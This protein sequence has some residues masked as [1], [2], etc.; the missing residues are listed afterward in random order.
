MKMR[1]KWFVNLKTR[2]KH[3]I[4]FLLIA[5]ISAVIGGL[6]VWGLAQSGGS[7]ILMII[8]GA[9]VVINIVA[10]I[11]LA[12]YTA[13]LVVDPMCK[14]GRILE[15]YCVGNL[16]LD[17]ILR[18]RDH[19]TLLYQ[20]EIG[21]VSRHLSKLMQYML[22]IRICIEELAK[23]DLSV[24]AP[25]TSPEDQIGNRLND[26]VNNFHR[27]V[28]AIVNV[29]N[30]VASNANLVSDSSMA[31]SQGAMHQA[32]AV[33][34]LTSSLEQIAAQTNLNAQNAEKAND[35]SQRT[36]TNAAEG[37]AQMKDMLTAMDDISVSSGS[38]G[39][40]IKVI[41]DIAFQ[42]NILALNAAVEAARAGQ[43]GKGFAV[44]AEEV[45][46]LAGKS[47]NAAR[48]T[49]EL[50]ENSIRKVETGAR[51]AN[52]T[53]K[54]LGEIVS[55]VDIAADL[56][57]SIAMAS[58]EQ[59]RGLDQVNAGITQ[60]SQVIQTNVATAQESAAASE[61]LSS[62]AARLQEQVAVF[63]LRARKVDA[64]RELAARLP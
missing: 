8:I 6:G 64:N 32:S 46:N 31:L 20:D 47:A 38:I 3:L 25:V 7:Q 28:A 30:Q 9:V 60:V 16:S 56:I 54:A 40:I 63:R 37:N 23:G 42:T 36:K 52:L 53:A 50:I 49:T 19:I 61:E 21:E 10:A 11:L 34:Q 14:N 48:E 4:S 22:D 13:Y 24:T 44:V 1:M 26:L 55:D 33:Q 12:L 17:G 41:D 27:L 58:T 2:G 29:S 43:Y 15:R 45:R 59:A 35:L 51:I 18:K 62:Q 39:K 57:Q 5:I